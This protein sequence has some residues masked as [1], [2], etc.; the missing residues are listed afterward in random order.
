LV[1]KNINFLANLKKYINKW[2]SGALVNNKDQKCHQKQ[3]NKKRQK[4]PHPSL[5]NK[6]DKLN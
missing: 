2:V 3:G 4:P 5:F 6:G 1:I